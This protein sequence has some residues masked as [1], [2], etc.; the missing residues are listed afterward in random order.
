MKLPIISAVLLLGVLISPISAGEIGEVELID[1]SVICG[2]ISSS[3]GGA[4]TLTSDTLGTVTIEKSKI[5]AIRFKPSREPQTHNRDTMPNSGQAQ[6]QLLQQL[7]MGD[8][9]ILQMI[10]SLLDDP[11][12]QKV[13]EDPSIIEAVNKGDLEA[14]FSNPKFIHLLNNPAIQEINRKMGE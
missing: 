1:G 8:P 12:I 14:L 2:E 7:L 13:L 4:Y 6:V 10:L 5:R 3:A 9:E 11:D